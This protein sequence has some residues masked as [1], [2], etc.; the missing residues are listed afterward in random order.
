[1]EVKKI[2]YN[3]FLT[4]L[5][6]GGTLGGMAGLL[7]APKSGRELRTDIRKTGQMAVEG[8][9]DLIGEVD[10]QISEKCERARNIWSFNKGKPSPQY[11]VESAE[12]SVGEA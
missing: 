8:A 2:K 9:R 7:F 6:I 4:G 12:E 10:R 11:R 5:F 1:M 3:H